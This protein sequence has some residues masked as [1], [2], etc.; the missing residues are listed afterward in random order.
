[1]K[2]FLNNVGNIVDIVLKQSADNSTE[3]MCTHT[4]K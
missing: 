4:Y 2:N 3:C 1:M